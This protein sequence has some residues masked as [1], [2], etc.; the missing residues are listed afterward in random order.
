MNAT[1]TEA[2]SIGHDADHYAELPVWAVV[3]ASNARHK[4]GNRIYRT[5]R[6]AGY[7]VYAVNRHQAII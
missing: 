6:E 2:A 7:R 4:Y 5:L 3:G 1:A